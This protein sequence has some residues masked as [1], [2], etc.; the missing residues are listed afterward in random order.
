MSKN[1]GFYRA[2]HHGVALIFALLLLLVLTVIGVATMSGVA[3]QERM[4]SNANLQALA[5]KAAS[6]GITESLEWG[7]NTASWPVDGD[8]EPLVCLRGLGDWMGGWTPSETAPG[9]ELAIPGI[10]AGFRVE[11]R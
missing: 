7:L 6:A 2:G 4:A 11:Y 10:P 9:T 3:M 1:I 8:G 5:F